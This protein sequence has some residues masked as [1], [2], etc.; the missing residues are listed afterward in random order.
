MENILKQ[1]KEKM[2]EIIVLIGDDLKTIK[3]GRAKPSLLEEVKIEA[4]GSLMA[5]REVGS[6]R[7]ADPH[8]LLISP[9]DK[10]LVKA[11]EK[12]ILS[13]NLHLSASINNDL[14]R[15][16]IPPLTEETRKDLV[17]LVYQKIESGRKLLRQARNETK[18]EIGGLKGSAGVSEDDIKKGVEE[19]QKLVKQTSED[20]ERLAKEKEVEL[21]TV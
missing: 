21:M 12:A 14:I 2:A 20:L 10:N 15:V 16:K 5:M 19:L 9:W 13:S 1:A 6:I 18:K 7:V 11:V 4:Y 17:K 8:T 3:T